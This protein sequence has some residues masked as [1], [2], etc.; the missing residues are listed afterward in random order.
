MRVDLAQGAL[1]QSLSHDLR[2]HPRLE[3][4]PIEAV[5]VLHP[6]WEHLAVEKS[7]LRKRSTPF[8]FTK[9]S[10]FKSMIVQMLHFMRASQ[11]LE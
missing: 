5:A 8:D 9:L 7:P 11:D 6:C 3:S 10:S 1:Q 4:P 2:G